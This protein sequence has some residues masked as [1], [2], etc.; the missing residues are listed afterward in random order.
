MNQNVKLRH[1]VSAADLPPLLEAVKSSGFFSAEEFEI[2][3]ELLDLGA[4]RE[5]GGG[6]RFIVADIDGIPVGYTSFGA[7]PATL[8]SYDLYWIVVHER[9]RAQKI[10]RVLLEATEQE[11]RRLGGTRL[12]ADTAG[13]PQYAPTHA[14]YER[15][16]YVR[17]AELEDYYAP[18]D[19]RVTFFKL[20]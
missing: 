8:A 6:Y 19:A 5:D 11:I 3:R 13:R 10:G 16:G 4:T 18:G 9:V 14:F 1:G 20:L 17:A 12:Y 7:V 15:C 2:A